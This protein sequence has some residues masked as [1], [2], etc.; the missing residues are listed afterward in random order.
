MSFDILSF[1]LGMGTLF[2]LTLL[3]LLLPEIIRHIKRVKEALKK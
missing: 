2:A 3:A 1:F